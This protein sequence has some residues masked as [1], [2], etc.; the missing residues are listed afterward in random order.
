MLPT[1]VDLAGGK[2]AATNLAGRSIAPAFA[3]DG[4][5]KR[6][7]LYFNHNHNRAIRT[8]DWKL[9]ATGD[10]GPWELYNMGTDRAE[11]KNLSPSHLDLSRQLAAK[12]KAVDDDFTRVRESA[13]PSTRKL[14]PADDL[15]KN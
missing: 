7:F 5:V 9:I 15:V 4:A 3:R 13:P 8:G 2:S 6:D 10:E 11:Q 1:L 12:W 14:M